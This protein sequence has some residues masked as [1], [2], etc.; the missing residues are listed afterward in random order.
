MVQ[1]SSLAADEVLEL[2]SSNAKATYSSVFNNTAATSTVVTLGSGDTNRSGQ[3]QIL[4]CFH[5]V[6]GYSKFGSYTGNGSSSG[7]TV[8]T[9]FQPDFVMIKSSS[10]DSTAWVIFDS[11][12]S[13]SNST[14]LLLQPQSSSAEINVGNA[15]D[16]NADNFQLKDTNASRNQNGQTY[17]YMAF[18]IN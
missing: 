16:F 5:D 9:G 17:I 11:A 6:T 15:M 10:L 2:N 12:R 13:P 14:Q 18:K 8:T 3:T 7:P 1:H 4:Y